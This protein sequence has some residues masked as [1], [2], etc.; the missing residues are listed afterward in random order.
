MERRLERSCGNSRTLRKLSTLE[1]NA[2]DVEEMVVLLL[3]AAGMGAE[4]KNAEG[5]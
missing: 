3:I 2:L 4:N 1:S 5:C